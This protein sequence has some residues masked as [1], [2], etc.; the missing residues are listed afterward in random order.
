[1]P[2][3][4]VTLIRL[5]LI[6]CATLLLTP[7]KQAVSASPSLFYTVL[8]LNISKKDCLSRAYTAIASEVTGQI[9]QRA[10]DVALVNN[11]YNLAVHCRRTSDKKSFITIMVTHQSSFQEAKELALSIQHAMETGSLR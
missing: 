3:P 2:I 7:I 4:I 6:I 11:D 1:M 10:D 9:L 8:P 5:L